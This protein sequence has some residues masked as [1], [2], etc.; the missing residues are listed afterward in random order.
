MRNPSAASILAVLALAGILGCKPGG[1]TSGGAEKVAPET[2]EA[3]RRSEETAPEATE[4]SGGNAEDRQVRASIAD[5]LRKPEV[6]SLDQPNLV[7]VSFHDQAGKPVVCHWIG[8]PEEADSVILTTRSGSTMEVPF[9]ETFLAEHLRDEKKPDAPAISCA[10]ILLQSTGMI[11]IPPGD[12]VS[13]QLT[14]KGKPVSNVC[15]FRNAVISAE[16]AEIVAVVRKNVE[17]VAN[18]DLDGFLATLHAESDTYKETITSLREMYE[19]VDISVELLTC[20]VTD[21]QGDTA[22]VRFVQNVRRVK[23][24]P[25]RDYQVSGFHVLKKDKGKW[26]MFSTAGED[27][28]PL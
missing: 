14:L 21:V 5:A 12:F 11:R 28:T 10:V 17:C 16:E 20:W 9:H 25:M 4:S 13:G 2:P 27:T 8:K 26:K 7:S 18:E 15:P 23:G 1:E 6:S 3:D 24:S 22:E 19:K